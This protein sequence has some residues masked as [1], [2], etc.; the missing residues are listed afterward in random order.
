[1]Q[2]NLLLSMTA[3][4]EK[5]S[6]MSSPLSSPEIDPRYLLKK[7]L[8][9]GKLVV[10]KRQWGDFDNEDHTTFRYYTNDILSDIE[11]PLEERQFSGNTIGYAEVACKINKT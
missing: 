5:L 1:M 4:Q 7:G 8:P 11:L 9:D 2:E 3:Y 10:M 6:N